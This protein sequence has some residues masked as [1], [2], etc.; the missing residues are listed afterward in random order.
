MMRVY[1]ESG[2]VTIE[3]GS[4]FYGIIDVNGQL[5]IRKIY[6]LLKENSSK[7]FSPQELMID[8]T[9]E[10]ELR[11]GLKLFIIDLFTK[12]SRKDFEIDLV[13]PNSGKY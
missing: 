4:N 2:V 3:Y 6:A 12:F 13:Q 8:D 10:K 7:A 11:E 1:K 9:I 5:D